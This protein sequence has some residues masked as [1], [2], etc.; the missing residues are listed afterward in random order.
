MLHASSWLLPWLTLCP[1]EME[2]LRSS[3]TSVNLY[4]TV[5][6]QIPESSTLLFMHCVH[7]CTKRT[8]NEDVPMS[9]YMFH[10]Q[11]YCKQILAIYG[12]RNLGLY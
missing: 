7:M 1:L 9:S 2:A 12:S 8:H 6:S 10:L 4:Q 11:N 3:E 5:R